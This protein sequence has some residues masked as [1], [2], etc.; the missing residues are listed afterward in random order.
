ME[1]AELVG[2]IVLF[3]IGILAAFLNV[4]AG[5][6]SSI[7]LPTLIFPGVDPDMANGT[8]RLAIMLQS[9]S[10]SASF[11]NEKI[12]QTKYTYIYAL[13]TI[14]GA[15]L[16][17]FYATEISDYAFKT[18]LGVVLVGVIITILLPKSK[19]FFKPDS[20]NR[21]SWVVYPG[22]FVLGFYGGFI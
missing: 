12:Y 10:A 19:K 3:F 7:T 16:G 9:A 14:P 15:I 17:S 2:T 18:V 11:R 13:L 8:N 22:F 21:F 6:G 20:E 1:L 5:G 4:T